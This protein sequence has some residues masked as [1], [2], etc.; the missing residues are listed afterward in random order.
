M[1]GVHNPPDCDPAALP[2]PWPSWSCCCADP[3]TRPPSDKQGR[4]WVELWHECIISC[5]NDNSSLENCHRNLVLLAQILHEP[6]ILRSSWRTTVTY[7]TV[8]ISTRAPHALSSS[9]SPQV[10]SAQVQR[11]RTF[12]IQS[13]VQTAMWEN[14]VADTCIVKAKS[15]KWEEI[16]AFFT[17][18]GIIQCSDTFCI[19]VSIYK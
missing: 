14:G 1:K 13:S 8:V 19:S 10:L 18:R 6:Q 3:G 5:K 2:C 9:I 4:T 17:W 7:S 15:G 16:W 11:R 12:H